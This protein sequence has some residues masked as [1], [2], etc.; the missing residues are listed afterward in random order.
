M[1]PAGPQTGQ[2][3]RSW[4]MVSIAGCAL[5]A[6]GRWCP[7]VAKLMNHKSLEIQAAM[8]TN[9]LCFLHFD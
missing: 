6:Q 1:S 8:G 4:V 2:R 7:L 5:T 9:F 3:R